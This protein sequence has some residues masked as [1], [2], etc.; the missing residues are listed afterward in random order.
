MSEIDQERARKENRLREMFGS[1]KNNFYKSR[2]SKKDKE[3]FYIEYQ[4]KGEDNEWKDSGIATTEADYWA[5]K[6]PKGGLTVVFIEKMRDMVRKV[7]ESGSCEVVQNDNERGVLL[8]RSWALKNPD[9][10]E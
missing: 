7:V 10:V 8:P 1:G 2:V 4:Q 3:K 5:G 9:E 6:I